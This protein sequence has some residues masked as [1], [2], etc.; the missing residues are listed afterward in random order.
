MPRKN[1]R[2]NKDGLPV[3]PKEWTEADWRTLNETLE[4]VIREV[5]GRHKPE[6]RKEGRKQ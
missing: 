5:S 6:G 3:D 4:K 1:P 2:L